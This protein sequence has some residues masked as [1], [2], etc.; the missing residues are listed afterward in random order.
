MKLLITVPRKKKGGVANYFQVIR[1]YINH[2]VTYIK[3]GSYSGNNSIIFKIKRLIKD[4]IVFVYNTILDGGC[5]VLV[6]TSLGRKSINRDVWYVLLSK[7]T[8]RKVCLFIHGWDIDFEGDLFHKYWMRRKII[9]LCDMYIVLSSEFKNK[10]LSNGIRA[11]IHLLTTLVDED[12]IVDIEVGGY[13]R[14][15]KNN[16]NILVLSRIVKEKGVLESVMSYNYLN[17]DKA[18]IEY[19]VAGDGPYLPTVREYIANYAL[20]NIDIIGYVKGQDKI[21]VFKSADIYL[22]PSYHGEGM[23]TTILEAMAFGLPIITTKVGGIA[24]FF[25]EGKMG[26]ILEDTK[27]SN[28]ANKV[29]YLLERPKLMKQMSVYNYNYAREN[30][31]ASKVANKLINIIRGISC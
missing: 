22:F 28:I 20:N 19:I 12:D 29:E 5:R 26:L 15:K 23:P 18:N 24:D 4:Y 8:G 2:D 14:Y 11:P 27:P 10:L 21:N 25:E 17:L 1:S 30:F 6:N 9:S 31:Y 13:S 16:Y 3:R 7:L